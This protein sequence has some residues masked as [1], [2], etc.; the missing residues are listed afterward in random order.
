MGEAHFWKSNISDLYFPYSDC[1]PG[2]EFLV[3]SVFLRQKQKEILTY[4]EG[5]FWFSSSKV[6]YQAKE[7]LV[8]RDLPPE[9]HLWLS[10]SLRK[11][12]CINLPFSFIAIPLIRFLNEMIQPGKIEL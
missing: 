7:I 10:A 4:V 5:S 9:Y 6:F 11:L 3:F 1:K 12:N 8:G 2:A